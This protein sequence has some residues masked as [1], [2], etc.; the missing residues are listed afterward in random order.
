MV[1]VCDCKICNRLGTVAAKTCPKRAR[2]GFCFE[3]LV[4]G[5]P[6][7]LVGF[8]SEKQVLFAVIEPRSPVP[9]SKGIWNLLSVTWLGG[10]LV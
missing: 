9:W 3:R 5:E 6:M 1:G 8:D 4:W 10:S 2:L 7:S